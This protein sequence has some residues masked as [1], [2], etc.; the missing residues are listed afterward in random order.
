MFFF[1]FFSFLF[2]SFLS[3]NFYFIIDRLI[4]I[5][6]FY[7]F[8]ARISNSYTMGCPLVRVDNPRALASGLSY[9]Q[10]DK[11][12]IAILNHLHQCRHLGHHQIFR[13]TVGKVYKEPKSMFEL[14]PALDDLHVADEQFCSRWQDF[15]I[16]S[17][18]LIRVHLLLLH[19]LTRQAPTCSLQ[20]F[21][22]SALIL[23]CFIYAFVVV[24]CV[25]VCVRVCTCARVFV[26]V[27]LFFSNNSF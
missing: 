27:C 3:V 23:Y 25:C 26:F 9:V 5:F 12:G 7:P 6:V 17:C 10:L 14:K 24:M 13:A 22:F 2:F 1:L 16:G 11:H 18:S 8:L 20:K 21:I 19:P 4:V 15:L